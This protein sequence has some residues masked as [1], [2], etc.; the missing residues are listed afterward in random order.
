VLPVVEILPREG[1]YDYRNKYSA[2]RTS[3]QAPAD[4]PAVARTLQRHAE[5]CLRRCAA[6]F[7][8]HRFPLRSAND[9][10]VSRSAIP[11]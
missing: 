9:P 1:F 3:Y 5:A 11:G 8:A 4:L 7:R 2:G 6:R 10:P